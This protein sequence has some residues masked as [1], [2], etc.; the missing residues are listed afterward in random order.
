MAASPAAAAA[1]RCAPAAAVALLLSPQATV[2]VVIK[3]GGSLLRDAAAYARVVDAFR[4]PPQGSR[5]WGGG[6]AVYGYGEVDSVTAQAELDND[7]LICC[8]IETEEAV[9][10]ALVANEDMV[11]RD[12]HRTPA[13]PRDRVAELFRARHQCGTPSPGDTPSLGGSRELR[14]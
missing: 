7:V 14:G 1:A 6:L 9:A 5:S 12:G 3:V 8:M 13:L 4:F 11:G 10:N 2:D